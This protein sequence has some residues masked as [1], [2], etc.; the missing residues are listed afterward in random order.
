[1]A[2]FHLRAALSVPVGFYKDDALQ[3]LLARAVRQGAFRLPG[4]AWPR[5]E[6]LPGFAL[7]SLVPALVV[8][9]HWGLL[10]VMGLLFFWTSLVLTWA[11]TRQFLPAGASACV[12]LLVGLNPILVLNCGA[13]MPEIPFMALSLAL[14]KASSQQTSGR[15]LAILAV[16][17]GLAT[18]LR[19]EG[20]ALAV[21]LGLWIWLSE[22]T[23]KLSRL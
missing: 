8:E 9:P 19:P 3:I 4:E 2:I 22:G 10:R 17:T 12:V 13:V 15:R 20:L 18:L 5:T 23:R 11:L 6:P 16:G 14:L 1:M 21:S 7:L